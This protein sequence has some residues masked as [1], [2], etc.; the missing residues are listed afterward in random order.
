MYNFILKNKTKTKQSQRVRDRAK[1]NGSDQ[2][3]AATAAMFYTLIVAIAAMFY[4]L[5][6]T[7]HLKCSHPAT[8]SR[9]GGK[10]VCAR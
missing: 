6:Y 4:T 5:I 8:S 1:V 2:F 7:P 10:Q 3:V 9:K